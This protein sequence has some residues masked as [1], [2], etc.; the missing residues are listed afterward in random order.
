[1][2]GEVG[3]ESMEGK[4]STFWF[5]VVLEKQ[6]RRKESREATDG[7]EGVKVLVADDHAAT[8]AALSEMLSWWGCHA[9]GAADAKAAIELLRDASHNGDPFRVALFDMDM[10]DE[11]DNTAARVAKTDPLLKA[12]KTIVLAPLGTRE[13]NLAQ[14]GFD[15]LLVKP[16]RR[17]RLYEAIK[18]VMEGRALPT[19]AAPG[20]GPVAGPEKAA[21]P[22]RI[23][24]A[25]DNITN[26]LVA[27]AILKR[28]G[29]RVDVAA[30]GREAIGGPP[31]CSVRPR[32]HGLP[33]AGDGRIR[34]GR[35]DQIGCRGPAA[36][37]SADRGDDREGDAGGPGEVPGGRDG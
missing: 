14:A 35:G 3:V 18:G 16:V 22:A 31:E 24:L 10:W 8:R 29:H 5:T 1:M 17:R 11:L 19:L 28:L 33:D 25:E 13:E 2:G 23:L 27:T 34:G 15:G 6:P 26:Q 32:A 36:P 21:H 9:L 20:A 37:V 12:T 4:G 30:N 7:L